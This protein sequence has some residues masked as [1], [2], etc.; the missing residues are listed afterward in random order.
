[1]IQEHNSINKMNEMSSTIT[2]EINMPSSLTSSEIIPR[3]SL[4]QAFQVFLL[5]I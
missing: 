4:P 5:K 2:N 3:N 1:M